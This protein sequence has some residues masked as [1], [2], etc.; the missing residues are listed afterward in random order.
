MNNNIQFNKDRTKTFIV[1]FNKPKG[2]ISTHKDEK[3]R[4]KVYDFIP[5][6]LVKYLGGKIHSIGRLDYNSQGLLLLTNNTKLKSYYENPQ[7]GI[8]RI[9]RVKIQGLIDSNQKK[10]I[11][12]GIKINNRI[13]DVK[14][15]QLISNTKT[16]SWL[17]ISLDK[18]MNQH[19]RKIFSKFNISVNKLIRIQYGPYKLANLKSG[20]IKILSYKKPFKKECI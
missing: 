18:G 12:E 17:K 19:I 13:H 16:Y 1:A 20:E 3:D 11:L 6:K 10:R 5:N 9:Y 4:V 7:S 8:I 14:S 2:V 15:L